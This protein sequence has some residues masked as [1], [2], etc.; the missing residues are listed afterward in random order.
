MPSHL[1]QVKASVDRV[2]ETE[3][4]VS[5]NINQPP[6][7]NTAMEMEHLGES[8]SSGD[9]QDGEGNNSK[10]RTSIKLGQEHEVVITVDGEGTV[11]GSVPGMA[12]AEH[13]ELSC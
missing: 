3:V 1:S 11:D 5:D 8:S 13:C 12:P 9:I 10:L 2:E 6:G 7:D 4:V